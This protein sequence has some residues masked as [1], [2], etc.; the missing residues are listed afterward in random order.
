VEDAESSHGRENRRDAHKYDT[1]IFLV[2][3]DVNDY[4]VGEI[5]IAVNLINEDLRENTEIDD[6]ILSVN[7]YFAL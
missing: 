7:K 3:A 1:E 6:G 5:E 2:R 4:P